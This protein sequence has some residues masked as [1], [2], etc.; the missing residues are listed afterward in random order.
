[1]AVDREI[2]RLQNIKEIVIPSGDTKSTA[3]HAPSALSMN[4]GEMVFAQESNGQLALYKKHKGLVWKTNLSKDGSQYVSKD[5]NIKGTLKIE[6]HR[7]EKNQPSFLAFNSAA[8]TDWST[9]SYAD[10]C[11]DSEVFDVGDNFASDTFTAPITGKYF[12]HT[13]VGISTIDT[14]ATY[15]ALKLVTSNRSYFAVLDPNFAADTGAGNP[16]HL[17]QITCVADMEVTDTAKVQLLQ[18]GGTAQSD[19]AGD[20]SELY[21]WFTGYLLG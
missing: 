8:D 1:M 5:L 21:T 11:F 9:G 10:V 7:E 3:S 17:F 20:S 6:G 15:Y 16:S 12:L 14:A 4:E 19:I 18:T 13:S 2:R